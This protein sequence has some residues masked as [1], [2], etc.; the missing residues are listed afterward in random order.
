MVFKNLP[1]C[2]YL[3]AIFQ[4]LT[5]GGHARRPVNAAKVVMHAVQPI[6]RDTSPGE[7]E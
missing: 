3:F 2:G 4:N 5:L 1:V 7:R 6:A